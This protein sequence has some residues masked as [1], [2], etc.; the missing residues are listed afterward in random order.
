MKQLAQPAADNLPSDDLLTHTSIDTFFLPSGSSSISVTIPDV[1]NGSNTLIGDMNL[2]LIHPSVNIASPK[3]RVSNSVKVQKNC[4][5]CTIGIRRF[6]Q[7]RQECRRSH[8]EEI[9]A[10]FSCFGNQICCV[11]PLTFLLMGSTIFIVEIR[12]ANPMAEKRRK[13]PLTL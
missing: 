10:Y 7:R 9:S 13:R 4:A 8:Q 1:S 11:N 12:G 3:V 6:R 2:A 5:P